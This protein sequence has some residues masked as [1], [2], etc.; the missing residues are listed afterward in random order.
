MKEEIK[1]LGFPT[2]FSRKPATK[3]QAIELINREMN[4]IPPP[5]PERFQELM[6]MRHEIRNVEDW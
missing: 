6:E 3:E 2:L 5:S 1:V 4:K